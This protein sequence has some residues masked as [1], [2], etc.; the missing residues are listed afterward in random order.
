MTV[1]VRILNL[2]MHRIARAIREAN[3]DQIDWD[4]LSKGWTAFP[5]RDPAS[6]ASGICQVILRPS[7]SVM[8]LEEHRKAGER[9]MVET[10][11]PALQEE[12]GQK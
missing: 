4:M 7:E 10:Y 5:P 3:R 6:D 1:D 11:G 12:T 2:P 9:Y 8:T